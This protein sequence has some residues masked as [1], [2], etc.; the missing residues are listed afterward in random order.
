MINPSKEIDNIFCPELK[1]FIQYKSSLVISPFLIIAVIT[2]AKL[3]LGNKP[4]SIVNSNF[5]S[6]AIIGLKN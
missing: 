2:S 1:F 4:E 3:S 5:L 6:S